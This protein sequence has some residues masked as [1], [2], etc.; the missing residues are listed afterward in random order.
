M[1]H[2]EQT[3]LAALTSEISALPG[4]VGFYYKN[5]VTGYTAGHRE[6]EA[7]LAASVIKFPLY[8][9]VLS[10]AHQG[11]LA[12]SDRLTTLEEDKVPSCG[13]LTLFTGEV[14]SD[15]ATLCRLMIAISDNTATNRLIRHLGIEEINRGFEA[16]GLQKT[17]LRRK[18]FDSEASARGIQ[19]TISPLEM[20]N[21]LESLYRETFLSPA[22]S[23]EAINTLLLQQIGHKLDG[24]LC[25]RYPIAHKTGEDDDLSNDVGLIL[26]PTPFILCFA[27]NHTDVYRFEDLMRRSTYDIAQA[28]QDA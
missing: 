8:L 1:P 18:L 4:Q 20:G 13:A 22:V 7:F 19:N 25:E 27:G 9:H 23:R 26:A 3:A 24:K 16:M 15:I 17:R 11:K 14:A 5:L 6:N 28:L 2:T 21:L 10:L 12:M